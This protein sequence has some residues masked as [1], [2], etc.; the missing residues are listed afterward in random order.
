[1]KE[2][3]KTE[4]M[5]VLCSLPVYEFIKKHVH[6]SCK[7]H[8]QNNNTCAFRT[9]T[10]KN[11]IHFLLPFHVHIYR[12]KHTQIHTHA[13]TRTCTQMRTHTVKY[14]EEFIL[15]KKMEGSFKQKNIKYP[16]YSKQVWQCI[17]TVLE[18]S[19]LDVGKLAQVLVTNWEWNFLTADILMLTFRKTWNVD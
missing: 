1:M 3:R 9:F 15:I 18:K 10:Q 11:T 6:T 2:L 17:E 14:C 5:K 4:K 13:H 7:I 16:N 8:M 12:H 19:D